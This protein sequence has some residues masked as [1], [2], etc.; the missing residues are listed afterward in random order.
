[1]NAPQAAP[2]WS[3]VL[4]LPAPPSLNE[5][6]TKRGRKWVC[7]PKYRQWKSDAG[8]T[9]QLQ[10]PRR[11]SG[12]F[13]IRL[14]ASESRIADVD[15]LLKPVLDLLVEHGVTVDDK[16]ARSVWSGR[17]PKVGPGQ[18]LVIVEAA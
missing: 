18:C 2:R 17:S 15:N 16:Y 11:G 13:S 3:V 7:T 5:L 6:W 14:Y 4:T 9:L 10:R 8:W 1:M 12:P